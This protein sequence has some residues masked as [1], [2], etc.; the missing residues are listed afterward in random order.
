MIALPSLQRAARRP[1]HTGLALVALLTLLAARPAAAESWS[2]HGTGNPANNP[3]GPWSYG[4]VPPSGSGFTRYGR[5]YWNGP[6]AVWSNAGI[7]PDA[8]YN[9]GG[10]QYTHGGTIFWPAHSIH[11][12]PGPG[13]TNSAVRFTAPASGSCRLTGSFEARNVGVGTTTDVHVRVGGSNVWDGSIWRPAGRNTAAFDVTVTLAAGAT[14]DFYVGDGGNGYGFD[15]TGLWANV[16]RLN[17]PPNLEV[18]NGSVTA[19]EGATAQN[20]GTWSDPEADAVGLTA[21][22]GQVVR[23]PDGTWAWSYPTSEGPE[24]SGPVTI[25]ATDA[26]GA[27]R[28][29]SFML[30]VTNSP[31][32]PSIAGIPGEAREGAPISLTASATDPSPTDTAAGFQFSWTVTRGGQ[33]VAS[34]V[35]SDLSFTPDDDGSYQVTLEARDR[36]GGV[37]TRVESIRVVNTPPAVQAS[38]LSQEVQYSDRPE[39]VHVTAA[40]VPADPVTLATS[41]SRDGG[42]VQSGLPSWLSLVGSGPWT[43]DGA[44]A[45]E[46]GDYAIR[47]TA[48]DDD[49]GSTT[50]EVRVVVQPEDARV[51]YT[52]P[53]FI[54]TE[55]PTGSAARFVLRATVRDITAVSGDLAHDPD[56][57]DI[58]RARVTFVN[59]DTGLPIAEVPVT[60]LD[61][62]DPTTG[63]A[64][65]EV[66]VDIGQLDAASYTIGIVVSGPYRRD[67]AEDNVVVVVS[68]PSPGN[69]SGGGYLVNENSAGALAGTRGEH[70]NF[71]F[72]ARNHKNGRTV[73]GHV[74]LIVRSGGR[75]FQVKSSAM[76]SL[77]IQDGAATLLAKAS[78]QDITDPLAPVAVEGGASLQL[79]LTDRGEPGDRDSLAVTLWSKTGALLFSSRWTGAATVEQFLGGGNLQAQ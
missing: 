31:P 79:T 62:A 77:A 23:N 63:T 50:V 26:R 73:H 48:S 72:N 59:R 53:L 61:G 54:S 14:V 39:A 49:G 7:V 17:N 12:H 64:S 51:T 10:S 76:Q 41:W 9:S 46:P 1:G 57:G 25:T 68:R 37:G 78:V 42:A 71:G 30:T 29:V 16:E 52:G 58:T 69:V 43:L 3:N 24:E 36:D 60:L 6:L 22:R 13:N 4:T 28:S 32:A 67:R 15:S 5:F 19:A 8:T 34:G 2:A 44:T 35:G 33:M 55:S 40:D 47:L 21:S 18:R 56:A 74:N 70:S 75:V 20:S 27:T 65:F 38:P 45:G 66:M 11:I